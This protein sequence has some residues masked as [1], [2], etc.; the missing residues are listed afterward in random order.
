MDKIWGF[1]KGLLYE[2]GVPSRTGLCG[3]LTVLIPLFVWAGVTIY[4]VWTKETFS[5]YT[6]MTVGVF[7]ASVS[8][9]ALA[10]GNKWINSK[11]NSLDGLFPDK[12]VTTAP[13]ATTTTATKEVK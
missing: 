2:N 4:L 5:H 7:G 6:D 12:T 11:F 13:A 9:G 10:V 8:G 3:V 1:L